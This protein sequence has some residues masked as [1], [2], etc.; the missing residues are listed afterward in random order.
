MNHHL[1]LPQPQANVVRCFG[2]GDPLYSA[3]HDYEWGVPVHDERDIFERLILEG[4]QAGL[5]WSTILHK[6]ENFRRAFDGFAI[7]RIAAY[8]E[9]KIAELLADAGIVR[10]RLKVRG[11]VQNAQAWL[12]LR[13]E[14]GDPVAWL[15]SFVGGEVRV[16]APP[17]PPENAPVFMPNAIAMS[18][19]LRKAGLTFVG[20][21][22]CYAFMQSVGMVNDHGADCFLYKGP[23]A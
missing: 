5:S 16:P 8:D 4:F 12:R 13:A 19:A 21:T 11:A 6:R 17:L 18:K 9:E 20:P 10:N 3:Y 14:T 7:E 1:P 23:S 22:I 2:A 15:W